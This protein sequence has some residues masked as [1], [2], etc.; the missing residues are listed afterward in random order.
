MPTFTL[1]LYLFIIGD[2]KG[3]HIRKLEEVDLD[4][5]RLCSLSKKTI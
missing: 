3:I 2:E 1:L 5:H 4:E